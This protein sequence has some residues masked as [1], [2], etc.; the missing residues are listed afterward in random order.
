MGDLSFSSLISRLQRSLAPLSG[1]LDREEVHL[2]PTL[3][4]QFRQLLQEELQSEEIKKATSGDSLGQSSDRVEAY[5]VKSGDTLWDLARERFGVSVREI[6]EQNQIDDPD[7]IAP[8]QTL[9]VRYHGSAAPVEFPEARVFRAAPSFG[10]TPESD[11]AADE[12]DT[13]VVRSGDTL[14]DL[15]VNRFHVH[16]EDLARE[17]SIHDPDTIYPGQVLHVGQEVDSTPREVLAS[18]YGPGFYGQPMANGEPFDASASTIAHRELPL[19]TEVELTNPTTGRTV[20]ATVTDR[21]PYIDGREVDLSQGLARQLGLLQQGVGRLI[22][23]VL[24]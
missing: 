20:R 6:A 13:Y 15:A 16:V 9:R 4:T 7:R 24:G 19:G 10:R 18:W 3:G 12:N 2:P 8:G 23:R 17:N 22:M 11:G 14:W 21:G 1:A 5:V